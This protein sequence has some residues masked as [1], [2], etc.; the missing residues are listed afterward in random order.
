MKKKVNGKMYFFFL[1]S[2]QVVNN[3]FLVDG[4]SAA[5]V[6]KIS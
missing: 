4:D 2:F 3:D 6:V 1:I 5:S